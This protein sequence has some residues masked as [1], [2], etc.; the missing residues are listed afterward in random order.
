MIRGLRR[1][2]TLSASVK[3]LTEPTGLPMIFRLADVSSFK[4]TGPTM[5]PSKASPAPPD[6]THGRPAAGLPRY[7][8]YGL[9]LDPHTVVIDQRTAQ[10]RTNADQQGAEHGEY[11]HD[12]E[13][14]LLTKIDSQPQHQADDDNRVRHGYRDPVR[15]KQAFRDRL[16]ATAAEAGVVDPDSLG[17]QL[18]VIFEGANALVASCND[19]NVFTDARS[20]AKTLLEAAL[21]T[22]P[23]Q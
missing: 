3:W 16:V 9:D 7:P 11:D 17:K 19:A 18:A 20:A 5:E 23:R 22:A 2:T 1:S 12:R 8:R 6:R 15:V 13:G 21:T 14:I 4:Q 10:G